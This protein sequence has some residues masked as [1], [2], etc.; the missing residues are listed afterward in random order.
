MLLVP[1]LWLGVSSELPMERFSVVEMC[2]KVYEQLGLGF[3]LLTA[4]DFV[5]LVL[6][7][8]TP[9]VRR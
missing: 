9:S 1:V 2:R 8:C 3:R 4:G 7:V 5:S 6:V